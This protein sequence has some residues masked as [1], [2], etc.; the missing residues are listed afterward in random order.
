MYLKLFENYFALLLKGKNVTG[1][2]SGN[3]QI[4]EGVSMPR[5][6]HSLDTQITPNLCRTEQP[7]EPMES[8]GIFLDGLDI[9]SRPSQSSHLMSDRIHNPPIRNT[10]EPESYDIIFVGNT[11]DPNSE[12]Q[13]DI[14]ESPHVLTDRRQKEDKIRHIFRKCFDATFD[15]RQA[16]GASIVYA[17]NSDPE[18]D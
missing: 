14:P 8:G 9:T 7:V 3:S 11:D 2:D 15:P 5:Q 12:S 4:R 18:D 13:D 10:E 16:I 6:V 1:M 17:Q